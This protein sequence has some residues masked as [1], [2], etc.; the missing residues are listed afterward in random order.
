MFLGHGFGDVGFMDDVVEMV[1]NQ[2][3]KEDGEGDCEDC[4]GGVRVD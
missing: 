2:E 3:G 1:G 4:G